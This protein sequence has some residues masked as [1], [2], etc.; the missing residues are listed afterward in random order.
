MP[1]PSPPPPPQAASARAM[2]ARPNRKMF[3]IM[4]LTSLRDGVVRLFEMEDADAD[5]R[6]AHAGDGLEIGARGEFAQGEPGVEPLEQGLALACT[7]F[8]ERR[9]HVV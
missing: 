3:L 7:E 8:P 2:P 6:G 1:P 9:Q 4:V 5:A